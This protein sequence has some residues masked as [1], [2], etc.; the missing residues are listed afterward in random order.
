MLRDIFKQLSDDERAKLARLAGTSEVSLRYHY[1]SPNPALRKIP[2]R[3]RFES[4]LS[5]LN[6]V[7]PGCI[8]RSELAAFF[9]EEPKKAA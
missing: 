8:S 1:L 2:R 3:S 6:S 9:Y 4:L 7:R 5:A